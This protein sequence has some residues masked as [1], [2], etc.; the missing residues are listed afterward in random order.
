MPGAI[1]GSHGL[2]G[3]RGL[4]GSHASR[5]VGKTS[6]GTSAPVGAASPSATQS[7]ARAPKAAQARTIDS[8]EKAS[9][10]AL[11]NLCSSSS[12]MMQP[13]PLMQKY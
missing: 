7:P 3:V 10:P 11:V 9:P 6:Q 12:A 5:A 1:G 13:D 4:G 8:F 2:R